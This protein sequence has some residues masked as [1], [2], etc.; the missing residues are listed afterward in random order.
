[1]NEQ[2]VCTFILVCLRTGFYTYIFCSRFVTVGFQFLFEIRKAIKPELSGAR[3]VEYVIIFS[4]TCPLGYKTFFMLNSGEKPPIV[5]ILTFM[6][7]NF[8][9]T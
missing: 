4:K 7:I 6:N 2:A 8:M 9:L 1:M 3:D 5:G